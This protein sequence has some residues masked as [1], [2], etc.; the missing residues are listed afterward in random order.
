MSLFE[1]AL[2]SAIRPAVENPGDFRDEEGMLHCGVC[3]QRKEMRLELIPGK[4]ARIVPVICRCV[5][6]KIEKEKY[7]DAAR[8]ARE[9]IENLRK[10]GLSDPLYEAYRFDYDDRRDAHASDIAK[11][12]VD[13]FSA[14]LESN[15][16]LMFF[17]EVGAGKSF[18]AGCIANALIDKGVAAMMSTVQGLVAEAGKEYG[19]LRDDVLYQVGDAK[20][21]ILDDFGVERDTE[22]MAEQTYEIINARYKAKMP[23]IITTN[24]SPA[25]MEKETNTTKR[26][27]YERVFEMCQMVHV[28]GKSR[29]MEISKEKAKLARELLGLEGSP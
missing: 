27:V 24:L 7:E 22:Y 13:R 12:Y 5:Q 23:L 14:F 15:V 8:A 21:L 1:N 29:R 17:G 18:L 25:M 28:N 6:E 4:P 26:R 20:L 2:Q 16:G 9:R 3:G 19:K 11:R 10:R